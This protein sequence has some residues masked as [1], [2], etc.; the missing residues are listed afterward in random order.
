M[1][2]EFEGQKTALL[3]SSLIPHPINEALILGSMGYIRIPNFW[4]AEKLIVKRR[5][6]VEKTYDLSFKSFG[7]QHE[8]AHVMERISSGKKESDLM[9]LEETQKIMETMDMV[10]SQIGLKY[11]FE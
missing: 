5:M 4:K 8:A 6:E 7:Y 11:P 3:S 9:P 1:V 2:L 10:R